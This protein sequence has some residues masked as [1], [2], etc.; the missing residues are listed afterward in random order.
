[1]RRRYFVETNEPISQELPGLAVRIVEEELIIYFIDAE[2]M[3]S[4]L[5]KVMIFLNASVDSLQDKL[6][7]SFVL[8]SDGDGKIEDNRVF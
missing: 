3:K 2:E 4:P 5:R 1:M 6:I 8:L 7:E